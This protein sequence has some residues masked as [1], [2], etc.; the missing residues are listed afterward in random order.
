MLTINT[1]ETKQKSPRRRVTRITKAKPEVDTRLYNVYVDHRNGRGPRI[2]NDK[3]LTR[4][5]A[6]TLQ[7]RMKNGETKAKS[8]FIM[9]A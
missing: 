9:P 8:A 7:E 6:L 1:H 3:P 2:E 5:K 4:Q